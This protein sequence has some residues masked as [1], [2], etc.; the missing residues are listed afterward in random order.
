[1]PFATDDYQA[2]REPTQ[3][4]RVLASLRR[5][6]LRPFPPLLPPPPQA[7]RAPRDARFP[8][9]VPRR[10]SSPRT[11]QN[12]T[13]RTQ[14]RCVPAAAI[15]ADFGLAGVRHG[16]VVAGDEVAVGRERGVLPAPIEQG[17][18]LRTSGRSLR[19]LRFGKGGSLRSCCQGAEL[20]G[21]QPPTRAAAA[22]STARGGV[23]PRWSGATC[24]RRF[25]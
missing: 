24:S 21:S 2:A 25:S 8:T 4:P 16:R 9:Q 1:M 18:R 15:A 12:S 3:V 13:A 11:R 17:N 20:V 7:L 23:M 5:R 6:L 14:V 19:T 10:S 22:A